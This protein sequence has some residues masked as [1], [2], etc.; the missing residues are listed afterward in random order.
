MDKIKFEE[1]NISENI[2]RAIKDM[3][4]EYAT[5]IQSLSMTPIGLD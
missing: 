4:Y 2:K 1:L 5:P 3:E